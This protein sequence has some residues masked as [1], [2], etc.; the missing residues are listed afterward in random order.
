M[1]SEAHKRHAFDRLILI[2][3]PAMLGDLRGAMPK[4]LEGT[5]HGELSKDLTH[6]DKRE[7]EGHLAD[8]IAV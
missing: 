7:L 6:A 4:D 2:A 5:I 3:P 8:M 1:L